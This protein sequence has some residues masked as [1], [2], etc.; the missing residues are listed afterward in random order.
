MNVE[1]FHD[2][3]RE[4]YLP[5]KNEF[6]IV[7]VPEIRYAVIDG[8]GDPGANGNNQAAKW[9]YSVVHL[10]KPFVKERMGKNFME[11]PLEYLYWADNE[12]DFIEGNKDKWNWRAM[13]V[14]I[15]WITQEQFEEA[16]AEVSQKLGPAPGTLRLEN[17]NEG[18]CVQIMHVGAYEGV[19]AVCDE[20]YNQYLPK[21]NLKPNGYYHEIYLNDPAR[22][23]PE[24]LKIV[25]RQPVA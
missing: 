14:F 24:K 25:I 22:T 8:Q 13:I 1:L 12:K 10:V 6:T 19:A 4:L 3:I 7:E 5:P 2:R 11:P 9:L 17:L 23:A 15:D 16:V 21:N 20:L 18:K